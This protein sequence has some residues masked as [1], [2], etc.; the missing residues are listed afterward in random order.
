MTRLFAAASIAAL[1][2][3]CT[4][5]SVLDDTD[6]QLADGTS[7]C[8]SE[9]I[10]TLNEYPNETLPTN[11]ETFHA[12][13]G[14]QDGVETTETGLQYRVVSEGLDDGITPNPSDEIFAHYHGYFP[15][16][17]VFDSSY[18]REEPLSGGAT[19][20][21]RGWNEALADMKVCE[22]RILYLPANLAYGENPIDRPGG[23]LVFN[24]QLLRV[25]RAQ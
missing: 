5:P 9:Q 3:A 18:V 25:N 8:P 19:H 12:Q 6:G 1:L 24:M 16:G 2:A 22:A 10:L 7:V 14:A 13:L 20:W 21:I 17:E 23:S 11:A 4:Q 15:N